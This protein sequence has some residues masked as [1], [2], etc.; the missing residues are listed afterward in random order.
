MCY[1]KTYDSSQ[2]YSGLLLEEGEHATVLSA[3]VARL[4]EELGELHSQVDR[5]QDILSSRRR[6]WGSGAL[7][8]FFWIS[9]VGGF[10]LLLMTQWIP[11]K[12]LKYASFGGLGLL[13]LAMECL[14]VSWLVSHG[15]EDDAG[16]KRG[17]STG[18]ATEA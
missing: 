15:R 12:Y 14:V 18:E 2:S 16:A 1:E 17:Y 8:T 6:I 7:S 10:T 9:E 4:V 13:M 3:E 5:L 11:T